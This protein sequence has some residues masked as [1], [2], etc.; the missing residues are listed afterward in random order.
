[1]FMPRVSQFSTRHAVEVLIPRRHRQPV[2]KSGLISGTTVETL[3]GWM[4]VDR[5][6][7]GDLVQTLDGGMRKVRALHWYEMETGGGVVVVPG[8]VLN[9]EADIELMPEQ[10]V[11]V[12]GPDVE[13]IYDRPAVM[14]R[15]RDM[16]GREGITRRPTGVSVLACQIEF[17]EEEVIW[18]NGGLCLRCAAGR[19]A[20]ESFFMEAENDLA[21]LWRKAEGMCGDDFQSQM[22]NNERIAC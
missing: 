11:L 17:D 13:W 21:G 12:D 15:A 10:Q 2:E 3:M 16:V 18:V 14:L 6:R 7:Q 5:L 22:A 1:M 19:G 20:T 4:P 8:G 9:N